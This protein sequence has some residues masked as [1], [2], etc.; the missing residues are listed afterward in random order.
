MKLF[1]SKRIL[2]GSDTP[3]GKENLRKNLEK[4]KGMA[5]PKE[6]KND[7]LGDNIARLVGLS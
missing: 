3:I 1:G 6:A 4:I 7:I 2:L 5:I